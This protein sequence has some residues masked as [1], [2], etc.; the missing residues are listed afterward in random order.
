MTKK[1]KDPNVPK[2][3]KKRDSNAPKGASSA[4]TL[5]CKATRTEMKAANPQSS[6]GDLMKLLSATFKTLTAEERADYDD[7]AAKDKAR[8]H[9]EMAEYASSKVASPESK[10][11]SSSA[12]SPG[13][14]A[15][16]S[17]PENKAPEVMADVASSSTKSSVNKA[18]KSSPS[19]KRKFAAPAASVNLLAAFLKKKKQNTEPHPTPI[20]PP[21][22]NETTANSE[23][24]L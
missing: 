18:A 9:T 19:K 4:F 24:I 5:Y 17:T 10:A 7:K 14:K 13:T 2:R 16:L 21:H 15:L 12:S 1:E 11:L 8:Y 6:Y 23:P 3:K 20:L 22:E